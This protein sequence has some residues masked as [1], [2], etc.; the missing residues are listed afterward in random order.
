V[1]S[2]DAGQQ[3]PRIEWLGKIVVR[4]HLQAD[5]PL[6]FVTPGCQH[7]NGNSRRGPDGAA[8]LETV[9]ARQ[10]HI[11]NDDVHGLGAERVE[12]APAVLYGSNSVAVALQKAREQAA[13][14]AVIIHHENISDCLGGAILGPAGDLA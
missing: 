2:F 7:N 3:L 1:S 9:S 8:K 4:A 11:E 6:G 14:L 13:N 12:Q 5:D 10:H